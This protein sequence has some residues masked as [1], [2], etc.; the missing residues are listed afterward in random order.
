MA[1]VS[2][3]GTPAA[4]GGER[5]RGG[6]RGGWGGERGKERRDWSKPASL[7]LAMIFVLPKEGPISPLILAGKPSGCFSLTE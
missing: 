1:E 3:T 7:M 6:G 4:G 2:R 5:V